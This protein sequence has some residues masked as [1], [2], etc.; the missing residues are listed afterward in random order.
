MENL[1]SALKH[2]YTNV[3]VPYVVQNPMVNYQAI[4]GLST[5]LTEE[6]EDRLPPCL[7]TPQPTRQMPLQ[8]TLFTTH[9]RQH[10]KNLASYR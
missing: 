5:A 10:I 1:Q 7:T 2:I 8:N 6:E 9:L 3:F 4:A